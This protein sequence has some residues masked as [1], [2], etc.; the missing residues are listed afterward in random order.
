VSVE[1][2]SASVERRQIGVAEKKET[3]WCGGA[4]VAGRHI[5]SHQEGGSLLALRVQH[6]HGPP[7][8]FSMYMIPL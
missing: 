7:L 3:K 8:H 1:D 2:I 4:Y 6:L 5:L